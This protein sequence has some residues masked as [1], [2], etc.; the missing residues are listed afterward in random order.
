MP[1]RKKKA[2]EVVEEVV[3]EA[4]EK[5]AEVSEERALKSVDEAVEERREAREEVP[6]PEI[7]RPKKLEGYKKT[8]INYIQEVHTKESYEALIDKYKEENPRK[9]EMKKQELKAKLKA[10]K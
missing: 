6:Q 2:E 9:Y 3:D 7:T 1:K 10:I 8:P 5:K 4:V